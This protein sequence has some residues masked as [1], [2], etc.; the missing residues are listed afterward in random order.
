MYDEMLTAISRVLTAGSRVCSRV[1]ARAGSSQWSAAGGTPRTADTPRATKTRS[2]AS[3]SDLISAA[4]T[5][6]TPPGAGTP[7]LPNTKQSYNCTSTDTQ[8]FERKTV[9]KLLQ[10]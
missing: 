9:Q 5:L 8:Q 4:G 6:R 1:C 10:K 2:L 7:F 3:E